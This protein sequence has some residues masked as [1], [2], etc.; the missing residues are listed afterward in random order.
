MFFT[1]CESLA[2]RHPNLAAAVQ[3]IDAQLQQM[4]TAE[5]IRVGDLASFL[6]LDPR[7]SAH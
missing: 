3:K 5:V 4:G 6:G 7:A 2:E 1:E